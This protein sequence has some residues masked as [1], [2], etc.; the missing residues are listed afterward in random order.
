MVAFR[1]ESSVNARLKSLGTL[2]ERPESVHDDSR[3]FESSLW[4][5]DIEFSINM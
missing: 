5:T 3:L 4:P 2:A 1:E